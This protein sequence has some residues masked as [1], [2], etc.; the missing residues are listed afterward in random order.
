MSKDNNFP[1]HTAITYALAAFVFTAVFLFASCA[2]SAPKDISAILQ[3]AGEQ[4][5]AGDYEA[6]HASYK[7]AC[8]EDSSSAEAARGLAH[9]LKVLAET[10]ADRYGE[11]AF[12]AYENLYALR[13]FAEEDFDMLAEMYMQRSEMIKARNLMEQAQR[14][15]PREERLAAICAIAVD[16]NDESDSLK[17]MISDI[18]SALEGK[19]ADSVITMLCSEENL[20]ALAPKIYEGYRKYTY[21]S[22]DGGVLKIQ[23]GC[24]SY[25]EKSAILWFTAPG[26]SAVDYYKISENEIIY[27]AAALADNAYNGP[28]SSVYAEVRNGSCFKENGSFNMNIPTGDIVSQV[29]FNDSETELISLWQQK[30]TLE[31]EE[32]TGEFAADGSPGAKQQGS[33]TNAGGAVYAYNAGG[34][35]YI[36]VT[37][38]SGADAGDP[39]FDCTWF[40]IEKYPEW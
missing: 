35:K 10:D 27:A 38:P 19:D 13:G 3:T 36:Y 40:G 23:A 21:T 17:Q 26:S 34:K 30:D 8:E 7:Q 33:V 12:A 2:S 6:A 31:Y 39:H 18:Y 11:E 1:S 14:L 32:Y 28:F 15:Y 5:T 9:S 24:A 29:Y 20:E 37:A 22:A 4:Y 25:G 16:A